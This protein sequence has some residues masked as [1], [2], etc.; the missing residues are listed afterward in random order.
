MSNESLRTRLDFVRMN[1]SMRATLRE[2]RPMLAKV[3]PGILDDFYGTVRKYPETAK[4][5]RSE[6]HIGQAKDL[7]V[8]HWDLIAS[9]TFDENYFNSAT[10]IGQAHNRIGLEPRWYIG[11]YNL[12]VCGLLRAIEMEIEVP[13]YG[14]A[15]QAMRAK[16]AEML[17]AVTSAALLDMDLAISIYL[18]SGVQAKKETLEQLGASFRSVIDTVSSASTELE[19]TAQSLRGTAENTTR[20][21]GVV[22]NAS[23]DASANVQSVASATEELASSVQEIARQV[24][25]SN[26]IASHAVDQATKTDERINALSQAAGRIGDVVKLITAIAEQTNLLALNATIEAARAGDA[27]RGFAVVA[28]EV[29]ALAAQ[30]AKATDEIHTQISGMQSATQEAVGS[31]NEISNTINRISEITSAIASAIEEQGAATREIAQNVQR[32]AQGTTQV[33]TNITEV[34]AGANETGAASGEVL[35]AAQSLAQDAASLRNEVD[36]FLRTVSAA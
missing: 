32:A 27:G 21:A 26:S 29:K 30:T 10:R 36:N 16:K 28:Q 8:R 4:L 24:Q 35:S 19:A 12:L 25:E 3:L 18:E 34:T 17:A 11:G 33:A 31:I 9:G 22:A 14:K 20:L 7:Q 2:L 1:E 6:Q 23:E 5:F 15:A 13:R